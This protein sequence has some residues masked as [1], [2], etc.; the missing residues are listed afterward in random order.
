VRKEELA[1]ILMGALAIGASFYLA[2]RS[3][4]VTIVYVASNKRGRARVEEGVSISGGRA[5]V[6]REVSPGRYECDSGF[7]PGEEVVITTSDGRVLKG[8][9]VEVQP[10]PSPVP[11]GEGAWVGGV[12]SVP[13]RPEREIG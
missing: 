2:T 7:S 10:Q 6:C 3:K 9:V 4:G 1:L 8:R 11:P 12:P 5:P 13:E